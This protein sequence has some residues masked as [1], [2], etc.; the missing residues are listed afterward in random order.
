MKKIL[1]VDDDPDV[2]SLYRL[3]LRQEGLEVYEAQDGKEAL[4]IAQAEALDLVLLDIMMPEMDGYEVCRRL[5]AKP[6]TKD[7]SI[8]L[9][10]AKATVTGREDGLLAGADDFVPKSVGPRALVARIRSLLSPPTAS[11]DS[12]PIPAI[13]P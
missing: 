8:L 1:I 4:A 6:D 5:R 2:R 9:F 3:V 12:V 11:A 7:V 10:S 13:R